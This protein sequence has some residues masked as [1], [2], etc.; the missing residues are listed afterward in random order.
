LD[1]SDRRFL[2]AS[3][4]GPPP[5]G[6]KAAVFM[7]VGWLYVGARPQGGVQ[8]ESQIQTDFVDR[9]SVCAPQAGQAGQ[10]CSSG[11][12]FRSGRAGLR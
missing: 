1:L 3:G 9:E 7:A 4:E 11:T 12:R 8:S 6:E 5:E 2:G 10:G